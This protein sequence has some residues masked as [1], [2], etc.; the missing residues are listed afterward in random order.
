MVRNG[1]KV[2]AIE[3]C[4]IE[5]AS[6]MMKGVIPDLEAEIIIADDLYEFDRNLFGINEMPEEQI[7]KHSLEVAE[8]VVE[9]LSE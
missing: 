9:M 5:C 1:H 8:K 2:I 6:R 3:G 7:K 4:F